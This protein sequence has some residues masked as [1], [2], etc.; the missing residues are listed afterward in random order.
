MPSG[1]RD[2]INHPMA[3]LCRQLGEFRGIQPSDICRSVDCFQKRRG[4]INGNS[5]RQKFA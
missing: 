3:D 1:A 2:D 5:V 4:H